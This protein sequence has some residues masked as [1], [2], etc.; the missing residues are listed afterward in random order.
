MN[1]FK[2]TIDDLG[3]KEIK[4]NGCRFTW[5]NE[6]HNPTMTRIDRL[7]CTPDWELPFPTCFLHLLPSLM[8]DHTPLLLLGE[9][10]HFNP[11]FTLRKFLA[12][13]GWLPPNGAGCLGEAS[14]HCTAHQTTPYQ[15]SQSGQKSQK[16]EKGENRKYKTSHNWSWRRSLDLSQLRRW[17]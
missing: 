1:S 4:L 14:S 11:L 15:T 16:V 8:S 13:N 10:E 2:A 17:S 5:S 6:Q 9:L 3:L 7:L 12:K